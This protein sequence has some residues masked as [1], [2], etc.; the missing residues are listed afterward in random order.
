MPNCGCVYVETC[1][2]SCTALSNMIRK[3]VKSHQ[4]GEC[5][6]MIQ[7][8]EKYEYASG[9][10]DDGSFYS[11]KTCSTCLEIRRVFF[12][13][14]WG[15]GQIFEHLYEHF[16]SL[17]GQLDHDCLLELSPAA[18]VVVI[19]M[20]DEVFEQVDAYEERYTRKS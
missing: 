17:G 14:A 7:P 20:L 12:C 6:C 8:G 4:C 2:D 3:A 15:Y 16:R 5:G 10:F 9:V 19:D 18:R 1:F 13:G 11:S